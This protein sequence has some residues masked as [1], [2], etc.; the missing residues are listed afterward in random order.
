MVRG[1]RFLFPAFL[2]LSGLERLFGKTLARPLQAACRW[3]YLRWGQ[4]LGIHLTSKDADKAT[5]HLSSAIRQSRAPG[6][7]CLSAVRD[8]AT[9]AMTGPIKQSNGCGAVMPTASIGLID[10]LSPELAMALGDAAGR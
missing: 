6:N 8:G 4:T 7:T 9:G 10:Q 5:L 1:L 3:A 2:G